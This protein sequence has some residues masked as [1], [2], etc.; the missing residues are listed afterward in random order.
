MLKRGPPSAGAFMRAVCVSRACAVPAATVLSGLSQELRTHTGQ[1]SASS[2]PTAPRS[3]P[4]IVSQHAH[5]ACA[6]SAAR[7]NAATLH[8]AT[9]AT[10]QQ[11]GCSRPSAA[12][13]LRNDALLSRHS[14]RT[15]PPDH[16]SAQFDC[17]APSTAT[18]RSGL[19]RHIHTLPIAEH[20]PTKDALISRDVG[21][22]TRTAHVPTRIALARQSRPSPSPS[23]PM[24]ARAASTS[25]A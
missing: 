20:Q 23:A 21:S 7:K 1:S 13:L 16:L 25:A 24:L 4:S 14:P 6:C 12:D 22:W 9:P 18:Q 8:A 5:T 10:Q 17:S 19:L 15:L 11:A 3:T 2:Q